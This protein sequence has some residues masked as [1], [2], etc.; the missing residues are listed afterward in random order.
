MR[1]LGSVLPAFLLIFTFLSLNAQ[2]QISFDFSAN[3]KSSSNLLQD[4]SATFDAFS[5]TS[6][7]IEYIPLPSL[8]L[9]ISGEQTYYRETIGLSNL[10]G[11]INATYIPLSD[12]SRFSIFINANINGR[13]YHN[14]FSGVDNNFG[15]TKLIAGYQINPRLHIRGGVSYRSTVYINTDSD[16]KRDLDFILG[17]NAGL[18]GQTS[19]DL[20]AGYGRTNYTF[21]DANL[22]GN[23]WPLS[24][25]DLPDPI[26]YDIMWIKDIADTKD[27][28]W[29]LYFSPRLSHSLGKKTGVSIT[30]NSQNFQ[31][32]RG[33]FLWDISTGYLSPWATVWE[34]QSV[35][36]NIK[37]FVLP[38][39]ILNA[40][41]GHRD[42]HFLTT[43][44]RYDEDGLDRTYLEVRTEDTPREDIVNRL[45]LSIQWPV[46]LNHEYLVEPVI[47]IERTNN[48]SNKPLY[49]FDDYSITT[50]V[51]LRFK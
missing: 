1:Y 46:K 49:N 37:S 13:K 11:R 42:K 32:Y 23:G 20:E 21:K 10:F 30:Y 34:G 19:F 12:K 2:A 33:G 47:N 43:S 50:G 29:V 39:L 48:N 17:L 31:N 38:K 15:E 51:S 45:Y 8:K 5:I 18:P 35:L 14:D 7:T 26:P 22:T 40:G 44:N 27:N 9:S 36:L 3:T 6:A 28:L 16:Y 41:Y 25:P 24:R 4:S